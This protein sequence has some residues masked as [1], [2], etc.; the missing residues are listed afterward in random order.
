MA[1]GSL[2][3][4]FGKTWAV[5]KGAGGS[6]VPMTLEAVH[7]TRLSI[8]N[9]RKAPALL[10]A[11]SVRPGRQQRKKIEIAVATRI[12]NRTKMLLVNAREREKALPDV[13]LARQFSGIVLGFAI[14]R[15][16]R[17]THR[18]RPVGLGYSSR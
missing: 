8:P 9:F 12:D 7:G 17:S 2:N 1:R 10:A 6:G 11:S 18:A 13:F 16:R 3:F 15:H 14:N 4:S 5:R